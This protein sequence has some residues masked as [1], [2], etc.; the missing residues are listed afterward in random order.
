[1]NK[2]QIEKFNLDLLSKWMLEYLKKKGHNKY[3]KI[4]LSTKGF[5]QYKKELKNIADKIL[6]DEPK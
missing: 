6:K 1:M 3:P 4:N 5:E 2:S